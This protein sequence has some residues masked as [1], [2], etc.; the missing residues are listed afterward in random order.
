MREVAVL[1]RQARWADARETLRRAEARFDGGGAGDLRQRFNQARRDL[2]LVIELDRIRLSRLTSGNLALYKT[3][4]DRDY[5]RA[6]ADSGLEKVHDPP[7][8]VAARIQV[9]AVRLALMAALDDWAV[10]ATDKD[11]RD[12]LLAVARQ[13]DPDQQGWRDRI[14]APA[15]WE[16]PAALAELARTVPVSGQ[17]VSLLLALGERLGAAGGDARAFL[18][19]VQ[20]E[21]PADFWAN[22]ILGD[23]LLRAAPAE[24]GGYY[25]AALASRPG[26][27]V[28][29]TALG[30]A[31][32]GQNL[33]EEAIRYYR[34]AVR[35]DPQYARGHTNLGN[36]LRDT[37]QRE[38]AMACYRRAL[39]IDPD[40]AW[41][42]LDLARTL[43]DVG[44]ADE[45]LEHYRQ[46]H[47]VGPP[48]PFVV[49]ILRSDLIRRG[50]GEE[51]RREWK[52]KLDLDPPDHD[53][54]FG[55]A[56]L[57]LFLGHDEEYRRARQDL[58][59]RFGATNE[60]ASAEKTARAILLRP[61]SEE[62]LRTAVALTERALAAKAT[63]P[64]WVYSFYLFARG[65]AE[66]RQ[67][68]FDNAI[69]IMKTKA[70]AVMGPCPRL[71]IA[72]ARYRLGDEQEA[73]K[74]LAAEISAIDW[75]L[76]QVGSHDQWI[77]HALRREAEAMIFPNTAAFLEGRYEPRDNTERLAL[78]GVCRFKDRTGA[79]ARLY[80][81]AFRADPKLADDPRSSHRYNAACAAARAAC[82]RGTDAAGVTE[83]ERAH[84]LKQA[85]EWLR[86]DLAAWA[87]A[88]DADPKAARADVRKALTRWQKGPDLA[89]VRE[90]GELDK[91][92]ADERKEYSAL[93]AEVTAVL[94]RT[95]K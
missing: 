25:R 17:S 68:H 31:L 23:A 74:L 49:N 11:R 20:T 33:R 63:T 45:A 34:L 88:F 30:D 83:T 7:D 65:L 57:C 2:D 28:G 39:E 4:A 78:L 1:Q 24:A 15:S 80:A 16:G 85:R 43:S 19:R 82:G 75:S 40:Y 70:G 36:F 94:A 89:Y 3:K 47:A 60:A 18:K 13:A 46:F 71:V 55:Y 12:W 62:E 95:E 61:P 58:V 91:L 44:R 66:Y 77:W 92:A 64:D 69:S 29:Y 38:E 9:S 54:W 56:E 59:R 76:A 72:M 41:A 22:L 87:R 14:R 21:H 53:A 5:T 73:R 51:V 67:G 79:S 8:R 32:H 37:G 52:K 26:A 84:W 81:D 90:P 48:I 42:H 50:R 27:A 93:W 6:F 86:A 35:I 10:C